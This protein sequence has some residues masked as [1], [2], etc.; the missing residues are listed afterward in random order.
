MRKFTFFW[1]LLMAVSFSVNAQVNSSNLTSAEQAEINA[2]A[3]F[4]SN[5][6]SIDDL[7][8]RLNQISDSQEGIASFFTTEE[9][10]TLQAHFRSQNRNPEADIIPTAGA[11]ETFAVTTGDFFF[12]PGGPGGSSTG[13]TPG[14]YPNCN[15]ITTTTLN[16]VDEITFTFFSVF[17]NFDWLKIYDSPDT[18]GTVLYDNGPGGA[19]DGDITLSD[20]I[21]S[22]GSSV[23]TSTGGSLTFEFRASAVVDYG[24]WEA[25]IT[26]G[27]GGGGG[28]GTLAYGVENVGGNYGN[29]DI[30]AP[31]VFNTV[32]ASPITVNFEGAGAIDPNDNGTAYV[33]DNAGEAFSVDIASGVYTSLGNVGLSDITGLE[34]D[35][36]DGTLYAITS[37]ELHTIDIGG[38]T[39]TLVGTTGMPLAVALAIDGNGNAYAHDVVDDSLWSIDLGTGVGTQVGL[40]GYDANFGQG[41]FWDENTDTIYISAFNNTLFE[42]ELRTVDTATGATTLV[43]GILPG[44]LAQVGWSSMPNS[45]SAT[46]DECD[47]AYNIECGDVYVGETLSDTD[48]GSNPANDEWF[49]FTGDGAPQIVTI[50]LCDGGTDYDSLLRVFDAC[51]GNEIATNDDSCGLQSE[52]NFYSDGTSTYYIMVEGFGSSAGNFSLAVTCQDPEPNDLCDG[53]IAI[54]CGDTVLGSTNN[55]TLDDNAP[56]CGTTVTSPGVWYIFEDTS[57]LASDYVVSLCDGGTAYDSKLSVYTGDCDNLVCVDGN[58][59]SCGLQSEVAFSGDGNTTYYIL[60]H[61]FGGATGDFSLN[62]TCIP[63][64]PDNDEIANAI[65]LDEVGCPFTDEDVAMPAATTEAGNPTDCDISGANGVWYKFTPVA[66][67]FIRGTIVTPAGFSSVTFYTAPDESSSENELVLVDWF[68]NQCLPSETA[69]IP[70]VAGQAYYA[71]V[72]NSGGITDIVFDECEGTLGVDGATIEGFAF[73]PN[74]AND[75]VNF[76]SAEIIDSIA[77]YNIL[78]QKV[79]SQEV[80]A[81]SSELSVSNL[82]TG[83][84]VMKVTVN[85]QV[86]TYKLIKK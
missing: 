80:N 81:T 73:Y 16:G 27:G 64:P 74:P 58:D 40:L 13:G 29:F 39:S 3:N 25:E 41:M 4:T 17:G 38:L 43:G 76:T 23:F 65:D 51:G 32:G 14:N 77:I 53:A 34:F 56:E 20:M 7:L 30:G 8:Q 35:P 6:I 78:G 37:L 36:S 67:G 10:R 69:R 9:I 31:A 57:G 26:N 84:Y 54:D 50:S 2:S 61:G 5:D 1:F 44:G 12:D 63:V 15:C 55:A 59:D 33:I 72:V 75:M 46:N 28:G 48:S 24:G 70:Y 22:Y 19:N 21:A 71:F 66:D 83:A 62:L 79:V 85:G 68:E 82:A 42:S 52:L 47:N 60:V 11:T 49:R 18:S 45:P 86:G